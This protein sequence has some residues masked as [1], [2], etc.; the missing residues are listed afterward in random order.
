MVPLSLLQAQVSGLRRGGARRIAVLGNDA[1]AVGA[2]AAEMGIIA[3]NDVVALDRGQREDEAFRDFCLMSRS[4]SVV[5]GSSAFAR[6][7]Q[8][9][10]GSSEVIQPDQMFS[11]ADARALL[12]EAAMNAGSTDR[13]EATLASDHLFQRQDIVLTQ[14]E[15]ILLLERTVELD[16]D[17]PTRWLGLIARYSRSGDQVGADRALDRFSR[18]FADRVPVAVELA[19]RSTTPEHR[20]GHLTAREWPALESV[21]SQAWGQSGS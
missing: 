19:R 16:P 15:E 10:A 17:D 8:L 13:V 21:I 3:P 12:W 2:V 9:I 18:Q 1:E 7:A 20:P 4:R 14:A 6:V 11:A 5:G